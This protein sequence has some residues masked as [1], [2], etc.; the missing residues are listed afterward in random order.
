MKFLIG[1]LFIC[2]PALAQEW[3]EYGMVLPDW[4]SEVCCGVRDCRP[5]TTRESIEGLLRWIPRDGGGVLVTDSNEF[6]PDRDANGKPNW[7][8]L[9]SRDSS[10]H[11]CRTPPDPMSGKK[12]GRTLCIYRGPSGN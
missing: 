4:Y 3:R 8:L 10:N 9:Q 2:S 11:I 7:R 5:V 6:F 1:L 12:F